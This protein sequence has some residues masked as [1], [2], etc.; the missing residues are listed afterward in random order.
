MGPV[1]LSGAPRRSPYYEGDSAESKDPDD[2]SFAMLPQG[3][4]T[5]T[6]FLHACGLKRLFSF[7]TPTLFDA[8]EF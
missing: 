4:L 8:A 3:V 5:G 6:S 1:I 2:F 7:D